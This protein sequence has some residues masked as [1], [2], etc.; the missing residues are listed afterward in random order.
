MDCFASLAMTVEREGFE[1]Q[2]QPARPLLR[3]GRRLWD[4]GMVEQCP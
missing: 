3:G 1:P 4:C 2:S